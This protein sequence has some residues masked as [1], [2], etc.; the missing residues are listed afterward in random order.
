MLSSRKT[1]INKLRPIIDEFHEFYLR[2]YSSFQNITPTIHKLLHFEEI[3]EYFNQFE[4]TTGQLSE[5]LIE[6]THKYTKHYKKSSFSASRSSINKSIFEKFSI[7]THM[8]IS[9]HLIEPNPSNYNKLLPDEVASE[10]LY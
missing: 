3:S 9:K 2:N 5:Q 7:M 10:F 1:K 6:L 4:L 8:S